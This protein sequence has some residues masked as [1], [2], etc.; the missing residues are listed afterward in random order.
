M[1]PK[2]ERKKFL[3]TG[4][5]MKSFPRYINSCIFLLEKKTNDNKIQGI[6]LLKGGE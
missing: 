2:I 5:L 1:S 3:E 4:E 6:G